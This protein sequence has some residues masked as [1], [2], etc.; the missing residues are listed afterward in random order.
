MVK[1]Q[2]IKFKVKCRY[3]N[4][5]ELAP[6]YLLAIKPWRSNLHIKV[7]CYQTEYFYV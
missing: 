5:E 7:Y 2:S 4:S 6:C 1:W 3:I